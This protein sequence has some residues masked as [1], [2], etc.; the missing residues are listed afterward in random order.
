M[1]RPR[2][3][4]PL[5]FAALAA[6]TPAQENPTLA[7]EVSEFVA[8]NAGPDIDSLIP[9]G[10]RVV[11]VAVEPSRVTIEFNATMNWRP[12]RPE[13]I[14]ALRARLQPVVE[15]HAPGAEIV[16]T[17]EGHPLDHWVPRLHGGQGPARDH[18]HEV[19]PPP[20]PALTRPAGRPGPGPSRGL[21]GRHIALWH[22]H[23][24]YYSEGSDRWEWQRPRLF[25]TIEDMLPM[26]FVLPFLV[27][28]LEDAG[29]VAL[30]PRERDFQPREV[31]VDNEDA[32]FHGAWQRGAE[33]GFRSVTPLSQ[34]VNPHF[35]GTQ[36]IARAARDRGD[37]PVA[38]YVP[39]I[40]ADGDYAVSVCF[41]AGEDRATD[42]PFV[43]HHAGGSTTILV[44]Q[45]MADHTWVHLGTYTFR[46]G[47]RPPT[48]R[49]EI[50]AHSSS[51]GATVSA[52]A[53]RFGGGM[54]TVEV[55]GRTSGR[56]RYMEGASYWLQFAGVPAEASYWWNPEW[57]QYDSDYASRPEWVNWLRGAPN[58]PNRDWFRSG[59]NVPVDLSLA[60][61]TDAGISADDTIGTLML[62]YPS[63]DQGPRETHFPD[64]RPRWLNRELGDLIQSQIVD[65]IRALFAPEWNRRQLHNRGLAEN[66]RPNV[67][68]ALLELLSHQ[69]FNDAQFE[70]DPRFRF[71]VARAIYKGMLRFIASEN[72]F[73]PV[74]AP[75]PPTHF[76]AEAQGDG[77]FHLSWRPQ[78]DPL[79]PT[80]EPAGYLVY[81]RGGGPVGERWLASEG[82]GFGQP[83][84]TRRPELALRGLRQGV[85]HSVRVTAVNDGGES[86]PTSTLAVGWAGAEAPR[87]LVVDAFD[88]VAPPHIVDEPGRRGFDRTVD[89]GVGFGF[90]AGL[91]GDQIDF[92]PSHRWEEGSPYNNDNPGHGAS[93]ADLE[94][95]REMGNLFDHAALH[96]QPLLALG[97]TVSAMTDE[98][99]E[100]HGLGDAALVDWLLGEERTTP[101]APWAAASGVM[102]PEFEALPP[103]HRQI[104][105]S[106]LAGGGR[107][108]LSGAHWATD[109]H[110]HGGEDGRR[111]LGQVLGATWISDR[112]TQTGRVLASPNGPLASPAEVAFEAGL[113]RGAS[114]GCEA[115]DAIN[116]SVDSSGGGQGRRAR[117]VPLGTVVLRYAASGS[118][119]AVLTQPPAP[120]RAISF[121]FPLECIADDQVR[122]ALFAAAVD[123]LTRDEAP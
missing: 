75:L 121:G 27:P 30:L 74:V 14:G 55:G 67:P 92:D 41:D 61:H 53:V 116:A 90:N 10:A 97:H 60:F 9:R 7:A 112:A 4:A 22:S 37:A 72:G 18:E 2:L 56:P 69:N 117:R 49:V 83:V 73:E 109:L 21:Q 84:F 32:Q 89:R 110:E 66:R 5:L 62:W 39:D 88:R 11:E 104:I 85:I 34:G 45:R 77:S 103:A 115:P 82:G 19:P 120:G 29:A 94:T 100:V 119:A 24:W 118:G 35:E 13:S 68:S 107:L 36:Q 106:H 28:M 16:M 52:D 111:F 15:A 65:D 26:S 25:T 64:G 12:M 8:A 6:A 86:F 80:A 95:E 79:E 50:V 122:E 33:P 58:G 59:G 101:P 91:V 44:N 40:P 42:V 96:A 123:L 17:C 102:R 47:R 43:V 108:I 51:A 23:G 70:L 3:A 57:N 98:A 63:G 105:E 38:T 31:I 48:G 76:A 20:G 113:G 93:L 87:A 54:G 46:A 78:S 81:L 1:I 71:A 99:A 114:Y